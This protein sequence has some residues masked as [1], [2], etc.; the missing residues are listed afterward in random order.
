M[1]IEIWAF[2]VNCIL[3]QHFD[4]FYP[5]FSVILCLLINIESHYLIIYS[6]IYYIATAVSL[7]S[8]CLLST[9]ISSF[10]F[11]AIIITP[12][13]SAFELFIYLMLCLIEYNL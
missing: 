8:P 2:N 10:H 4:W 12:N 5:G 13:K 9:L 3:Q 6:F 7:P 1:L 11:K